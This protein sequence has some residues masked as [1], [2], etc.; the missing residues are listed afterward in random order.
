MD[1]F[2]ENRIETHGP[3]TA[4][5]IPLREGP[6]TNESPLTLILKYG[7]CGFWLGGDSP[8]RTEMAWQKKARA[9]GAPPPTVWKLSHH[10]SKTSSSAEVVAEAKPLWAV[11]SLGVGNRY[12]HPVKEVMERFIRIRAR[13]LR[14][15]FHGYVRFTVSAGGKLTCESALGSCGES[16]CSGP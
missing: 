13:T 15:D 10:G 5:L 16:Q 6:S 7:R 9:L 14:T 8:W 2:A 4:Y 3:V 11:A 12:G 1:F